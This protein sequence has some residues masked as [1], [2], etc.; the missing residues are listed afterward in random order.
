MSIIKDLISELLIFFRINGLVD[1]IHSGNYHALLTFEGFL[2]FISPITP[3]IIIFEILWLFIQHGFRKESYKVPFLIILTNRVMSRLIGISVLL[4]AIGIFQK[5]AIIHTS[6]TWYWFIYSYLVYELNNFIRH[7]LTHKVRLLWCFHSVHH[8]SEDLNASITLTTFF[9]ENLYTEFFAAMFCMLLG[10]QP[11]MLFTIMII[12]SIWGAFVHISERSLKNARLGFLE[13]FILTPSHHRVHHGRNPL[14]MDTNFC[15][16]INVW[17]IIFK[18]YQKEEEQVPVDYGITRPIDA[19][20]FTD[21]YFG[22]ILSLWKDVRSA[23]GLKNKI[24][25]IFMPPGWSHTGEFH[26]AQKL[27]QE[28]LKAIKH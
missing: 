19:N 23:P 8:A 4:I 16:I 15:S 9:V 13:R 28:A 26:T 20:S 12:D 18:T 10:V 14:Y 6:I 27:R 25:Y 1:I 24:A 11:L 17:D 22:E 3:L 2:T 7:Y 5:Y 21:V